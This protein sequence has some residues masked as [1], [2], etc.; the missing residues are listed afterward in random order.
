MSSVIPDAYPSCRAGKPAET[1]VRCQGNRDRMRFLRLFRLTRLWRSFVPA[2]RLLRS[3]RVPLHLKLIAIVSA[4][5]ILSP[6]NVLGDIPFLG[7]IDDIAL[8]GILAS[9][10][11]GAAERAQLV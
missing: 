7:V 11:V 3:S 1:F 5:V 9:W 4:L 6:L 10:F 2:F 8:L